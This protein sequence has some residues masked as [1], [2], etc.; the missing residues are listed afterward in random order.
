MGTFWA[1]SLHDPPAYRREWASVGHIP[2]EMARTVSRSTPSLDSRGLGKNRSQL[3]YSLGASLSL[4]HA[5]FQSG[6]SE[7][8]TE[9]RFGPVSSGAL[10]FCYFLFGT[11][12][13]ETTE[14]SPTP[15]R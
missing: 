6:G 12:A 5:R 4:G 13:S 14:A 7:S 1:F 10:S 9:F 15:R 2:E 3:Q 11:S 8:G